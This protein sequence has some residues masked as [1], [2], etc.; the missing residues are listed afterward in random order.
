[1]DY[2]D[3]LDKTIGRVEKCLVVIMLG[4]MILVA[5]SQIVLRNFFATGLSWGDPLVRYM[6]LWVGFIG[7]SLAAKEDSHISIDVFSRWVP[8]RGKAFIQTVSHLFSCF[9]CA[10]L[11]FA[12]IVFVRNEARLGSVPFLGIPAWVLQLII[13]VAF[14]LM[15]LRFAL[16]SVR[17]LLYPLEPESNN[18]PGM[19]I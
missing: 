19:L 7:A 5:F 18:D 2:L 17:S 11:T 1:M 6:V 13:P 14:G 12:A 16:R 15:T 8:D 4:L 10:L 9:I 3:H